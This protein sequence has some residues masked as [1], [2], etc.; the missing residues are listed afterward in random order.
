MLAA[1]GR[2]TSL[3]A[4]NDS[5]HG[6]RLSTRCKQDTQCS[7]RVA[8]DGLLHADVDRQADDVDLQLQLVPQP[9]HLPAALQ[10]V[11]CGVHVCCISHSRYCVQVS[12]SLATLRHSAQYSGRYASLAE[13]RSQHVS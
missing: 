4:T 9:R 2:R 6:R 5:T 13:V 12:D 8:P 7:Y 1:F 3:R 10:A 11:S